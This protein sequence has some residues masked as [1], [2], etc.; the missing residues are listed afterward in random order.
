MVL[1]P[2]PA[3]VSHNIHARIRKGWRSQPSIAND[4]ATGMRIINAYAT[5]N[6]RKIQPLTCNHKTSGV[7]INNEKGR[8]LLT[9]SYI[10]LILTSHRQN[11]SHLYILMMWNRI[12][13][14]TNQKLMMMWKTWT[15]AILTCLCPF[16]RTKLGHFLFQIQGHRSLRKTYKNVTSMI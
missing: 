12:C 15:S 13:R 14:P 16:H 8:V 2:K 1:K 10:H 3:G 4:H 9:I 6:K 5:K 11:K 7:L